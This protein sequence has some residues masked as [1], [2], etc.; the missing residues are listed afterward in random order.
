MA[1]GGLRVSISKTM[2]DD[3]Q[4][5]LVRR[6]VLGITGLGILGIGSAFGG[7]ADQH[8][9]TE[10]RSGTETESGSD[11]ASGGYDAEEV[12]ND[13]PEKQTE[14]A[15][16]MMDKYGEP[17]EVVPSRIMW[18]HEDDNS[19]WK[20]TII[21]RDSVQ[22][23]FPM[24]HEDF[25]EQAIDLYIPPHHY[26][27][28][29]KFDGSVMPERTRGEVAARC[30]KEAMNILA[31]N[32]A[33]EL[34]FTRMTVEEARRTYAENAMA[35]MNGEEPARTQSFHFE[36][37]KDEERDPDTMIIRDGEIEMDQAIGEG[38]DHGKYGE[39]TGEGN[40]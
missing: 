9:D 40:N 13:W 2:T 3:D 15:H 16:E 33:H 18:H 30:D 19:V 29:A 11:S 10:T 27:K 25:L 37:P 12:L 8:D 38:S 7:A 34:A 35:Y 4:S 32:L 6:T 5:T 26:D 21:H 39:K 1:E 23:N 20:H 28:V 24:E 17:D 36:M 31:I 22:H 14:T